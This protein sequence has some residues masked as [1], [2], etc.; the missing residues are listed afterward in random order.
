M[1]AATRYGTS[2]KATVRRSSPIEA[3]IARASI[4]RVNGSSDGQM[5]MLAGETQ[6]R[7]SHVQPAWEA[8][9]GGV[10]VNAGCASDDEGGR[11]AC[12]FAGSISV[13]TED[14]D[15]NE[16]FRSFSCLRGLRLVLFPILRPQRLPDGTDGRWRN[17]APGSC[18]VRGQVST[19]VGVRWPNLYARGLPKRKR[20]G[21]SVGG[22]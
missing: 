11:D 4:V 2:R 21:L 15:R 18:R 3:A 9:W 7:Q 22:G 6:Q 12:R 17:C 10:P 5:H 16:R 14:A 1:R 13:E 8:C 19:G 20:T